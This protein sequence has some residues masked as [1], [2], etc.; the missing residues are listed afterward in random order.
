MPNYD[1]EANRYFCHGKYY[2]LNHPY[3][4]KRKVKTLKSNMLI[5]TGLSFVIGFYN[6]VTKKLLKMTI[7][8]GFKINL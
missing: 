6:S 8:K 3:R 7:E 4:A 5:Y 1:L 2:Y